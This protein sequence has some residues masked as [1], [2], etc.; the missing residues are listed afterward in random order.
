MRRHIA[1]GHPDSA[2]PAKAESALQAMLSGLAILPPEE[3]EA[4]LQQAGFE[5]VGLFYAELSVKGWL[6]YGG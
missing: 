5:G 4:M 1:W 6:G 3:E 2:D